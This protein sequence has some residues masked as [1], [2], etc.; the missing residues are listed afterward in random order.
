MTMNFFNRPLAVAVIIAAWPIF[1]QAAPIEVL[2]FEGDPNDVDG[3][4]GVVGNGWATSW[5][6]DSDNYEAE[7]RSDDPFAFPGAGNHYLNFTGT[8]DNAQSVH[9]TYESVSGLDIDQPHQISFLYRQHTD[10]GFARIYDLEGG[11]NLGGDAAWIVMA[12][13][14]D[15]VVFDGDFGTGFG[16]RQTMPGGEDFIVIGHEYLVTI[17]IRP[18]EG[19]YDVH[20]EDLIEETSIDYFDAQFRNQGTGVSGT[21]NFNDGNSNLTDFDIDLLTVIP[22]PSTLAFLGLGMGAVLLRRR[23]RSR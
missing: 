5:A 21:I 6:N 16:D 13:G 1:A 11:G 20:I 4:P 3:Y 14:T 18:G 8:S 9:R 12:E 23:A 15:F 10:N 19:R 17:D 22:E 2:S 7:I